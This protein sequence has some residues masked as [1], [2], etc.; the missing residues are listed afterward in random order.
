M[1][2]Q[3]LSQFTEKTFVADADHTFIWDTAASI[4]KRVSRNSWL[5]SGTLTSDAPVTISQTWNQ[6]GTAFTAF[7][8][9]A[10][11]TASLSTSKL[12][13]LQLGGVSKVYVTRD[14]TLT[15]T[16][17]AT[18]FG[19][20]QL[21]TTELSAT[22]IFAIVSSFSNTNFI[23]EI[24]VQNK[25]VCNAATQF[26]WGS[27]GLDG[28]NGVALRASLDTILLRDGAAN[29]LALRNGAAAQTF[30]VY[31]TYTSITDYKRLSL[32]C[33]ATTGN[34]TIAAPFNSVLAITGGSSTA[35][36]IATVNFAAQAAPFPIGSTVTVTG[37]T[38]AGYN[39][40]YAV[41][42]ST[43][44]SVSYVNTVNAAWVSGG[45][46][47]IS[48]SASMTL[49]AQ[50]NLGIGTTTPVANLHVVGVDG[51]QDTKRVALFQS[52]DVNIQT[53]SS[54]VGIT[55]ADVNVN[56]FQHR[57]LDL[58]YTSALSGTVTL[59]TYMRMLASGVECAGIGL[60]NNEFVITAAATER[61]RISAAGN[62][63][64]GTTSPSS[65][66]QVTGGD[67]EIETVTS[68]IIMKA[69]GTATR[70]RITLNAT[71]DA[72]VFTAI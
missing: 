38:P 44:T 14:G 53:N 10:V 62:V 65:K 50:G 66:L 11:S 64:I 7:K 63:G 35:G 46:A 33:S 40:T 2:N 16:L 24:G 19:S 60:A 47:T 30:N 61:L 43:T 32:S 28:G 29:T 3:N 70:Y 37:V 56:T 31:G 55:S 57:L 5:N 13:D 51:D 17:N 72:L 21:Y 68:G 4:S 54:V 69:A 12:L 59:G 48:G 8:V 27:Q 23:A 67:V 18:G 1:A 15:G 25:I 45:T 52:N 71:G 42:A 41:T 36:V 9:N 58:D 20:N 49:A 34:A 6:I 26:G 39:G 22:G